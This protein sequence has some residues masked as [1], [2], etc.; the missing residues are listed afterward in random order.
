VAS[1]EYERGR[2][3]HLGRLRSDEL[4]WSVIARQHLA[5]WQ[6]VRPSRGGGRND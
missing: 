5:V 4:R 3:S 1:D 6:E 2:L